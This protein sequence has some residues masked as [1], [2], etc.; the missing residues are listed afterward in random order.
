MVGGATPAPGYPAR[1]VA[2]S[3]VSPPPD[4]AAPNGVDPA[5]LPGPEDRA[6]IRG[7]A[8]DLRFPGARR[9]DRHREVDA[10]GVRLAVW[11][12][13]SPE[14]PP[15]M[16]THGGFDFAGTFDT[17]APCLADAGYRVVA[18]DQRG[19][20]DS[21]KGHLY[22]WSADSRDALSVLDSLG[23]DPVPVVG[24]SKGG[25][26][27]LQLAN[28]RPHR[29]SH[30]INLD[31]MPTSRNWPDVADHQRTTMLNSEIANRLDFRR[32]VSERARRPGTVRE[33]AERRR[34]MNSRHDLDFLEYLV[35]IG[36]YERPDGWRW[37]IDPVMR[38]GG[39]GPWRPDWY[40]GLLPN[41]PM[42]VLCVLG[43]QPEMM[44]W[45]T[46]P[47]DVEPLL[48]AGGRLVVLDDIGH[49]VHIEAPEQV[50]ELILEHIS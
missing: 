44:G 13:G 50:A 29:I 25:A 6:P 10:G 49:F 4:D 42:P 7:Q 35:R 20:G 36:G 32:R 43:L 26:L 30:L 28:A 11:E 23:P 21:S 5:L 37:K 19:H 2:C 27:M 48:P 17:L 45:G 34:R 22:A 46:L 3:A 18:W 41:L 31:G 24:H 47:G 38:P 39:F 40:M 8:D 12:W 9:P 15:L 1:W 14:D 33:L 16:L